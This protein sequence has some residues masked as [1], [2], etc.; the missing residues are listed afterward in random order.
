[1]IMSLKI[2]SN[3]ISKNPFNP[4]YPCSK[5][6]LN[7]N[8]KQELLKIA[9][10]SVESFVKSG[11]TPEF[12]VADKKLNQR[13]GAFVTLK[14]KSK[15]RG[16]IGQIMPGNKPLWQV[17]Q[18]MAIAAAV[19][20]P[21]FKPVAENELDKLN[22]EISVLS[23]PKKI[24]NWQDIEL[25]R[26]GVIVKKGYQSGVFLPQVAAETGWTL[27]EF[28]SHLCAD[29]AGLPFDCYKND[30]EVELLIFEAQVF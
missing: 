7:K 23:A 11:K 8:Q 12:K 24:N 18:D 29:K 19:D 10:Q 21:R 13:Q 28:L 27:E 1:M 20:D 16:C 3:L 25:G 9:R 5:N 26:H 17:V 22:Y 14:I 30:L 6:M 4:C 15:L 2:E